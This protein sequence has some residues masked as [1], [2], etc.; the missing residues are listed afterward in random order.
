MREIRTR[1]SADLSKSSS[2]F[3]S[4]WMPLVTTKITAFYE[5][6][7]RY[8]YQSNSCMQF[9]NTNLFGLSGRQHPSIQYMNSSWEV[10]M[11]RAHLKF[12]SGNFITCAVKAEQ[13]GGSPICR[14]F[15]TSN[16]E[17]IF[18]VILF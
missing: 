9:L 16:E 5:K 2:A 1:I 11:S 3:K 4:A 10:K 12:L 18:D 13:L 6:E 17:T 7:L 8:R 14:I 15:T